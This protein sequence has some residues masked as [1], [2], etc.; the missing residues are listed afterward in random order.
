VLDAYRISE[1]PYYQA[2]SNELSAL[3]AAHRLGLPVLLKGPS[4]CGKTRLVA[5]LAHRLS[6]PL[7]TVACNEDLS[8]ADLVGR[9]VL[10][11][12]DTCWVD[13]PLTLAARHGGICYLDELVEARED[14]LV[15]IHPL[16]DDRRILPLA[17]RSELVRAHPAFQLLV[18]FNP[19]GQLGKELK[20]STRQRF[21]ALEL[22]YPPAP[23]ESEIVAREGRTETAVAQALVRIAAGSRRL[24][25]ESL[26]QGISTRMLIAA[27]QLIGGGLRFEEACE[28]A[29]LQPLTDDAETLRGL[30]A[31]AEACVS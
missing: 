30:R 4:G 5:H 29:L 7:V 21:V 22:G 11:G 19:D 1:R 8:A 12:G 3:E 31:L 28:L 24:V 25:G 13:G 9:Y 20:P 18:S 17:A 26:G 10:Q 27:A 16:T 2:V 15:V 23:L 6:L 14:A